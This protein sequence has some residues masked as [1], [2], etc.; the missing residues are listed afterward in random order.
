MCQNYSG[1]FPPKAQTIAKTYGANKAV[2][3][4]ESEMSEADRIMWAE[5]DRVNGEYNKNG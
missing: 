5:I 4:P 3:K 1:V 2:E